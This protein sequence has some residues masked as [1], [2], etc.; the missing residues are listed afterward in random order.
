MGL[1]ERQ[2]QTSWPTGISRENGKVRE[3]VHASGKLLLILREEHEA[4]GGLRK[5]IF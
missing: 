1:C 5:L 2:Y 4:I 3:S